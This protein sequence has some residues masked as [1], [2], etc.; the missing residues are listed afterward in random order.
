MNKYTYYRVIQTNHGYGWDD[1]DFH[2]T[3]SQYVL[4]SRKAFLVNL[5]AYRDNAGGAVR[6]INRKELNAKYVA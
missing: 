4:Y 2:E 6:V 5:Q 1:A 3:N